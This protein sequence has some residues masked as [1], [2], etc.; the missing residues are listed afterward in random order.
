MRYLD[1]HFHM[2][3]IVK[4][5]QLYVVQSHNLIVFKNSQISAT[6]W[7]SLIIFCICFANGEIQTLKRAHRQASGQAAGWEFEPGSP[8]PDLC[9]N[10]AASSL[11]GRQRHVFMAYMFKSVLPHH[12]QLRDQRW[13]V[14]WIKC[15]L[16]SWVTFMMLCLRRMICSEHT[17]NLED[18]KSLFRISAPLSSK[19]RNRC[20]ASRGV[21]S[22][23]W[24]IK[25][26]T[27][28]LSQSRE[29]WTK[30]RLFPVLETHAL[31]L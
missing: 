31:N 29:T 3:K 10:H 19:E 26:K 30:I 13:L 6:L 5:W 8:V 12:S 18:G 24:P 20:G 11:G 23:T 22:R 9:T 4:Y 7:F 14:T 2:S 28:M 15:F 21:L 17:R 25:W 16:E 1:C 27:S